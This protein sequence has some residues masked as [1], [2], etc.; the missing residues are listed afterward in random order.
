M[1]SL[2]LAEPNDLERLVVL[3]PELLF[4]VG[5]M[6]P[7]TGSFEEQQE[8][9]KSMCTRAHMLYMRTIIEVRL[10]QEQMDG[11]VMPL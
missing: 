8:T 1:G 4:W 7:G 3:R 9:D 2:C 5:G 11:P 6:L 10:M